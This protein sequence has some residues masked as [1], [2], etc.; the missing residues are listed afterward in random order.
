M[1]DR[2]I[3]TWV[4]YMALGSTIATSL[5]GLVAGGYYI[6]NYLDS[7]LGTDPL[8]KVVLMIA[9]VA[10]GISYLIISLNKLGNSNDKE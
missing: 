3:S 4:K 9:G 8:L 10:L 5:A 1:A 7:R 6:G 2:N